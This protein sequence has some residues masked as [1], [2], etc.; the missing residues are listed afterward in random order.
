FLAKW[1][2]ERQKANSQERIILVGDFNAFQ[3]SDGVMD[4]IGT[5]KG[6]P[7]A[8]DSVLLPSDDLV[9][10]DMINLVDLIAAPQRY[11]YVYDGNAQTLDHIIISETLK[12]HVN[13]FG[14]VRVN[15]DFPES[16]RNDDKRPER[17]SDH[18]PAIAYFTFDDTTSAKSAADNK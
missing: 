13:G 7:A 9:M 10:R 4:M 17:F 5:I 15:A 14:F 16:M 8:K 2:D 11:S 1:V 3:F 18:D 12:N 6:T